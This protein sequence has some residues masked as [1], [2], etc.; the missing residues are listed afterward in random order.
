MK[1]LLA[2]ADCEIS[3]KDEGSLLDDRWILDEEAHEAKTSKIVI[4]NSLDTQK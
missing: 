4:M 1:N 3:I 2:E